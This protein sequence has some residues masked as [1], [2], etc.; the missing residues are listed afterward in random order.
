[1]WLLYHQEKNHHQENRQEENRR[2]DQ[3]EEIIFSNGSI[4]SLRIPTYIPALFPMELGQVGTGSTGV[5][6]GDFRF[7]GFGFL[8]RYVP[9]S[10]DG[11]S[12][13]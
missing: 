6:V 10:L 8:Q 13:N 1:M 5:Q 7:D 11:A 9:A 3:E 2:Q 4:V 12:H